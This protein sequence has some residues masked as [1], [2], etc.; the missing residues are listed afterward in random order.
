MKKAFTLIEILIVVAMLGILAAI[1][2]PQ[3]QSQSDKAREAA[4]KD[5]LRVLRSTIEIYAAQH[6]DYPPGYTN[7]VAAGSPLKFRVQTVYTTNA[8]GQ[9]SSTK[10]R[11]NDYPLGPYLLEIPVNP[12]NDKNTVGMVGLYGQEVPESA[13]GT[14]GW[15]YSP[16]TKT[17]K[18][19]W[20]GTDSQGVTYYDY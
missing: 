13:T 7:G 2:L 18:L 4:A 14:Y 20:P 10:T 19:D 15:V 11:S 9:S 17:I 3:F 16:S 8:N 6:K 5:N 1:A 12:F